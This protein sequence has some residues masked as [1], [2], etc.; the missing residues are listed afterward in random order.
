MHRAIISTFVAV[1]LVASIGMTRVGAAPGDPIL[2]VN[3]VTGDNSTV[4][5]LT[6][7][8]PL[9][10]ALS[11]PPNAPFT[12]LLS[13]AATESLAQGFFLTPWIAPTIRSPIH[14]VFDGI[15]HALLTAKLGLPAADLVAGPFSPVFRFDQ[16]GSFVLH[17]LVPPIAVLIDQNAAEGPGMEFGPGKPIILA[18]DGVGLYVQIVALD[19]ATLDL[20]VG[21]GM[22]LDFGPLA[23]PA[24]LGAAIGTSAQSAPFDLG[25]KTNV[26]ALV[27]ADMA[28]GSPAAFQS[29]PDFA[30]IVNAFDFWMIGLAGPSE[31]VHTSAPPGADPDTQHVQVQGRGSGIELFTGARVTRNNENFEYPR[32]VLPGGRELFHWR[33]GGV[34]PPRYGFGVRFEDQSF[35]NLVPASFGTFTESATR[36]PFEVEVGVSP[37]GDRAVVILDASSSTLDRAFLLNLEKGQTFANGQP[38]VEITPAAATQF[39]RGFDESIRFVRDDT[40][41]YQAFI[42]SS[43]TGDTAAT[44]PDRLWR[45]RTDG[46]ERFTAIIPTP[47]F[48]DLARFDFIPFVN[49]DEDTLVFIAGSDP[50]RENVYSISQVSA[51]GTVVVRDCTGFANA[52]LMEALDVTDGAADWA[53]LSKDGS[54]FAG[55]HAEGSTGSIPFT[56]RTDGSQAGSISNVVADLAIGGRFDVTDF[57]G[58]QGLALT[59]DNR[60]LL[61]HQ[62]TPTQSGLISGRSDLFVADLVSGITRNLTRTLTGPGYGVSTTLSYLGPWDVPS[63]AELPIVDHGGTF[64]SLDRRHRYFIKDFRSLTGANTYNI[65][66]VE[67]APPAGE[68]APT[69]RVTN[70]TGNDLAPTFGESPPEFG[71]PDVVSDASLSKARPDYYRLRRVGGASSLAQYYYFTARLANAPP[72]EKQIEQLLLFDGLNPGPALQLTS[73]SPSSVPFGVENGATIRNVTP[74]P[75]EPKVAFVLNRTGSP[76]VATDELLVQ[77]LNAFGMLLRVPNDGTPPDFDRAITAGSIHWLDAIPAGIVYS[78]GSTPRPASGGAP[79]TDGV[80]SQADARNPIDA[81]PYFFDFLSPATEHALLAPA[82][83]A[84]RSVMI[85]GVK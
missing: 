65:Y 43:A 48:S 78:A 42:F 18:L 2:T 67:V 71:A 17:G 40:G 84:S 4:V 29:A 56:A 72:T 1:S 36:S 70:V 9:E 82:S 5:S 12:L 81:T 58:T 59:D 39:R 61:F 74:S 24:S 64:L 79:S 38:I 33:N 3:G 80:P 8:A 54:M 62:G 34:S 66:A 85:L 21:N 75:V 19:P 11:G 52:T 30:T 73:F 7:F 76:T 32:I 53:A 6:R 45:V 27:D 23:R 63:I 15:G 10:I 22:R 14:P 35:R 31:L 46:A 25:Q 47:G 20:R 50:N 13:G 16:N 83:T 37:D 60:F 26:G 55:A 69:F 28:D 49:D 68:S 77:D 41:E 44:R 57:P 51:D